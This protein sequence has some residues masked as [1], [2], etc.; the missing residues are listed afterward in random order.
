MRLGPFL[1]FLRARAD[2]LSAAGAL[3]ALALAV[4][5]AVPA[6]RAPAPRAP[7]PLPAWTALPLEPQPPVR[8]TKPEVLVLALPGVGASLAERALAEGTLHH[9]AYLAARGAYVSPLRLPEPTAQGWAEWAL[10]TGEAGPPPPEWADLLTASPEEACAAWTRLNAR[11]SPLWQ[12]AEAAGRPTGLVLWPGALPLGCG[13]VASA[14]VE[15]WIRDLPAGWEEVRLTPV[16]GWQGLPSSYS[17]QLHGTV[18]LL[19]EAGFPARELHL[20]ALDRRN[21]G[22]ALYDHF[23][24]DDDQDAGRGAVLFRADEWADAWVLPDRGSA[25]AFRILGVEQGQDVLRVALYRSPAY[26]VEVQPQ[27][28]REGL[29]LDMGPLSPPPDLEAWQGGLLSGEQALEMALRHGSGLRRLV[30]ALYGQGDL[31]ALWVR[32]TPLQGARQVAEALGPEAPSAVREVLRRV[33]EEVGK[34]LRKVDL[35]ETAV[36]VVFLPDEGSPEGG[37]LIAAGRDVQEGVVDGPWSAA[38]AAGFMGALLGVEAPGETARC[39]R[40]LRP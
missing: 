17:E 22:V 33:D 31:A 40:A 15:G 2:A 39:R 20:I 14:Q 24:L 11:S 21:D 4:L 26:H 34:L 27:T 13:K 9:L 3:L 8:G 7:A 35:S 12:R 30:E 37:A 10:S 19:P 38:E 16:Q 18:T 29:L 36:V 23:L 5:L 32:W 1:R 28:L 25:A 6:P